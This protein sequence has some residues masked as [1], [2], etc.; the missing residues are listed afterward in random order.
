V[1]KQSHGQS[2]FEKTPP[3]L[4]LVT[5]FAIM[6]SKSYTIFTEDVWF[7]FRDDFLRPSGVKRDS[8]GKRDRFEI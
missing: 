8:W 1:T 3:P 7:N 2:R 6:N 5:V 4:Q